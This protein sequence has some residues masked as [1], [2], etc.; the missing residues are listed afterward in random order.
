[1]YA[2]MY[3]YC[4]CSYTNVLSA[5]MID[6]YV[7]VCMYVCIYVCMY[8]RSVDTE[9]ESGPGVGRSPVEPGGRTG[10]GC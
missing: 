5:R 2:R 4:S 6:V 10:I 9:W 7:Y 3:M 8:V 1:M